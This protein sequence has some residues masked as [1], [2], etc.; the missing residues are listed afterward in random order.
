MILRLLCWIL[1]SRERSVLFAVIV[2]L[3]IALAIAEVLK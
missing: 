1:E 3:L 2:W